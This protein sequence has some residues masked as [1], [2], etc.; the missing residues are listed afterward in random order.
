M[1][2]V[3][4]AD[5]RGDQAHGC[6][7]DRFGPFGKVGRHRDRCGRQGRISSVLTPVHKAAPQAAI[8]TVGGRGLGRGRRGLDAFGVGFGQNDRCGG[9]LGDNGVATG[10]GGGQRFSPFVCGDK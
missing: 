10:D 8:G 3:L 9:G 6:G 4:V 1:L 7:L 2:P 5:G